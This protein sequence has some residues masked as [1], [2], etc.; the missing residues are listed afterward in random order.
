MPWTGETSSG[1][2]GR[3]IWSMSRYMTTHSLISMWKCSRTQSCV[4]NVARSALPDRLSSGPRHVLRH[5]ELVDDVAGRREA[6]LVGHVARDLRLDHRADAV[7]R[8]L[9]CHHSH[10]LSTQTRESREAGTGREV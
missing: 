5:V 2:A 7:P 1:T 3:L 8:A 4:Q 9:P 6:A 10:R